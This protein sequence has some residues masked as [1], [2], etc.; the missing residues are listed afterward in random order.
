VRLTP[1]L[2]SDNPVLISTI[3]VRLDCSLMLSSSDS[4]GRYSSLLD[5]MQLAGRKYPGAGSDVDQDVE[6]VARG[7]A[8]QHAYVHHIT[9]HSRR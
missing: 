5:K 9:L 2:E 1:S 4:F 3:D 8:S 6:A 7:E